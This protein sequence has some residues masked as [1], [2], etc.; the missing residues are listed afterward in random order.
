[1]VGL[2]HCTLLYRQRLGECTH[3]ECV[4]P[5]FQLALRS[6]VPLDDHH[7]WR[8]PGGCTWQSCRSY[9]ATC[10]SISSRALLRPYAPKRSKEWKKLSKISIYDYFA[11]TN[12]TN[13][14]KVKEQFAQ[15]CVSTLKHQFS[16]VLQPIACRPS[17]AKIYNMAIS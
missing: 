17:C 16:G 5:C 8:P 15:H 13:R 1:M 6:P 7:L 9:S 12:T 10:I 4:C 11:T 14:T 2:R 3:L